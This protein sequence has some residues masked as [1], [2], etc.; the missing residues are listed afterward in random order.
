MLELA[1]RGRVVASM[2]R[3][4]LDEDAFL[5]FNR[6]F[7]LQRV[8]SGP[9]EDSGSVAALRALDQSDARARYIP[10]T[11]R[12][13]NWHTDGYYNPAERRINAFA[14]YCVSQAEHGGRNFLFD[15]ELMYLL[16]R[17][18]EPGLLHA[19]M[20]VDMMHIPAN[21][22]HFEFDDGGRIVRARAFWDDACRTPVLPT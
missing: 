18:R 10:Y 16:I 9:G 15:H 17:D 1:D 11:N 13:L 7:G 2:A 20:A 22:E 5:A 3:D 14:L 8:E 12:A 4:A 6:R 19:L 21:V